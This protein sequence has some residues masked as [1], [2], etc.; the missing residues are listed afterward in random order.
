V[1]FVFDSDLNRATMRYINPENTGIQGLTHNMMANKPL[2]FDG[3]DLPETIVSDIKIVAV[4]ENGE[5][6]TAARVKNNYQRLVKIIFAGKLNGIKEIIIIPEK[7]TGKQEKY[8]EY[9]HIFS[10]DIL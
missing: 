9:A 7:T 10:I 6:K 1:R 4:F 8:K 5:R 3:I 2:D